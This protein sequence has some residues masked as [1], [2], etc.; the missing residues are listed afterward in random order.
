MAPNL[1]WDL[2]K[3]IRILPRH[4][5]FYTEF[6]YEIKTQAVKLNSNQALSIDQGLDNW[7]TCVDTH[8]HNFIIDGK[9]L[10]SKNQY[11]NKQ[12]VTLKE[13]KP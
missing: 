2:M 8:D 6:I 9:H 12:I 7:L 5:C 11:Y 13:N 10:K 4:G 1:D 3:E